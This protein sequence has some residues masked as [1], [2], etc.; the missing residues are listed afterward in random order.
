VFNSVRFSRQQSLA[1]LE[2]FTVL[3]VGAGGVGGW[4]ALQLA[5]MGV[6]KIIIFDWDVVEECNLPRQ[7]FFESS[8]GKKKALE[9]KK[10]LGKINKNVKIEVHAER[11]TGNESLKPDFVLDGSDNRQAR[12]AIDRFCMKKNIPWIFCGVERLEFMLSTFIPLKSKRFSEWKTVGSGG[13]VDVLVSTV[14]AAS[15]FQVSELISLIKEKPNL[16][17]KLFYGN[18]K[19]LNF[20]TVKIKF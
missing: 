6:K 16:V 15:S 7:F 3:I 8:V 9:L 4:T 12:L 1:K 11:F 5:E 20:K 14:M 13:C 18:L 10:M 19:N 2:D 17:G